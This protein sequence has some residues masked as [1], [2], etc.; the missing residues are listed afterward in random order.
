M[1]G[2]NFKLVFEPVKLACMYRISLN[3]RL[4]VYVLKW[5][6]N[7][8]KNENKTKVAAEIRMKNTFRTLRKYLQCPD[9]IYGL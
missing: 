8:G 6:V 3:K 4:G 2:H 7:L 9:K 1:H 5:L